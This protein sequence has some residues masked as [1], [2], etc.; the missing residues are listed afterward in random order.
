M[1]TLWIAAGLCSA[2]LWFVLTPERWPASVHLAAPSQGAVIEGASTTV[3]GITTPPGARVVVLVSPERTNGQ[4]WVQD[5]AVLDEHSG[6]WSVAA[7]LGSETEGNEQTYAIMALA[8]SE[9][10]ILQ[11]LGDRRFRPGQI[12]RFLPLQAQSDVLLVRRIDRRAAR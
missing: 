1:L 5:E 7:R 8:T 11:A 6:R 10:S 3:S 12:L 9:P 4:W 2:L